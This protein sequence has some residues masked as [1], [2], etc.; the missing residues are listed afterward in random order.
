M[1]QYKY[2]LHSNIPIQCINVGTLFFLSIFYGSSLFLS[3]PL[4]PSLY[5]SLSPSPASSFILFFL[6]PC[7]YYLV[8][9]LSLVVFS[10]FHVCTYLSLNSLLP[11]LSNFLLTTKMYLVLIS[12]LLFH[13]VSLRFYCDFFLS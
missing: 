12:S 1:F 4:V 7:T 11:F 8:Q 13:K 2:T 5:S 10:I 6:L 9:V 3:T